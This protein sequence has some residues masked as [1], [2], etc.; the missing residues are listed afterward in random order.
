MSYRIMMVKTVHILASA[1]FAALAVQSAAAEEARGNPYCFPAKGI[2][3]MV[4]RINNVDAKRRDVVNVTVAPKFLIRD[5]GPWPERFFIRNDGE[6]FDVPVITP[7]GETPGFVALAKTHER[8]EVCVT[9]AA[10]AELPASD[11]S[12]YFEMGLSPLFKN[13][14]GRH[15]IDELKE[16]AKDG[17]VFYKQMVPAAFRM[18]TPATDSL[19]VKYKSESAQPKIF[20]QT[21]EGEIE[22]P[23]VAYRDM[24]VVTLDQLEEAGG[25]A[26]IVKGGEYSLQPTPTVAFMKRLD[27][28]INKKQKEIDANKDG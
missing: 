27:N 8:G 26:L 9:D 23:A 11:E 25:T 14:S 16:G 21:D 5:D 13:I 2:G 18:F 19:A 10:R 20:A 3:N 28:M 6:E 1:V 15:D 17:K 22:L 4:E 24:Y 7:S 12:L